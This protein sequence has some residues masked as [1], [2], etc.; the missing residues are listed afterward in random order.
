V[1]TAEPYCMP[2]IISTSYKLQHSVLQ[3]QLVDGQ[4]KSAQ[5]LLT[6]DDCSDAEEIAKADPQVQQIL[7]QRGITDL[8]LVAADPWSV[9]RVFSFSYVC[10][11]P[12]TLCRVVMVNTGSIWCRSCAGLQLIAA[13][14]IVYVDGPCQYAAK[15]H[16]S[17]RHMIY[18]LERSTQ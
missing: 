12:E 13:R 14:D 18:G 11:E 2:N 17:M 8:D 10:T 15:P 16:L 5:P 4:V 7:K 3:T 9:V 6:P 1:R